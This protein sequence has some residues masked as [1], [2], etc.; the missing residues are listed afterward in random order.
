MRLV[1]TRF[2]GRLPLPVD[3]GRLADAFFQEIASF[4]ADFR[5]FFPELKAHAGFLNT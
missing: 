3:G 2:A 1:L 4:E 5:A